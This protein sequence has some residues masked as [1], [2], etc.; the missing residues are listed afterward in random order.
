MAQMSCYFRIV[1]DT[2]GPAYNEFGYIEQP[3]LTNRFLYNKIID[4]NIVKFCYSVCIPDDTE[5]DNETYV[6]CLSPWH[7]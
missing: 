2:L 5:T 3:T 6:T 7:H 1:H 4:R